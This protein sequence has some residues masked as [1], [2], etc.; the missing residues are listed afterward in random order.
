MFLTDL[1]IVFIVAAVVV[2]LFHHLRVPPVVGL[3]VAGIIVGPHG[4]SLIGDEEGVHT[5]AEVGIVVL[6]FTVG[7][8]FSLSRLVAMARMMGQIGLP[9][10]LLCISVAALVTWQYY[11]A[12]NQ[13]IFTGML[14]TMSSTAIV[15][16]L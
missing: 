2:Y 5:L 15:F 7:L 1:L 9:Q 16:R 4:L 6:L 8:E 11:G 13:A 3:L 10:V 14:V 12:A